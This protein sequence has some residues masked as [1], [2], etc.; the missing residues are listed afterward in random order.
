MAKKCFW[1]Q[2]G[3]W[4]QIREEHSPLQIYIDRKWGIDGGMRVCAGCFSRVWLLA[5]PWTVAPPGSSLS[6][7]FSK[8]DHWSGLP[9]LSPGESSQPRDLTHISYVSLLLLASSFLTTSAIWE[10]PGEV[11]T[12]Y[13]LVQAQFS[14]V[15][16]MSWNSFPFTE[17]ND[18]GHKDLESQNLSGLHR[19]Y[20][21]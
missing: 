12:I 3:S 19:P 15:C 16:G 9:C 14:I 7:G 10:N 11:I 2:G 20:K 13:P 8:Q 17:N 1:S 6:M 18:A 5:T 4:L 21:I